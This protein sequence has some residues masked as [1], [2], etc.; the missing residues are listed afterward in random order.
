MDRSHIISH[1][2]M[3]FLLGGKRGR[4][5]PSNHAPLLAH[6][7]CPQQEPSLCRF[8]CYCCMPLVMWFL[9]CGRCL[10]ARPRQIRGE[11]TTECWCAFFKCIRIGGPV[12][13]VLHRLT[14]RLFLLGK[15]PGTFATLVQRLQAAVSRIASDEPL[16]SLRGAENYSRRV[17]WQC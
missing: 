8:I 3:P 6:A 12:C 11:I 2:L 17:W 15:L 1:A 10:K 16:H 4:P 13:D 7:G 9:A 5:R 14:E